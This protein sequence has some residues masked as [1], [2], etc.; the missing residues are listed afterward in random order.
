MNNIKRKNKG[1]TI[2]EV[3]IS[4]SIISICMVGIM[5]AFILGSFYKKSSEEYTIASFLAQKTLE[6]LLSPSSPISEAADFS[7]APFPEPYDQ[8]KYT[9][10]V[11]SF[12]SL[13]GCVKITVSVSTP[14]SKLRRIV[15]L[16][17]LKLK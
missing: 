8:Y 15:E 13:D 4:I 10:K 11:T 7:E 5:D 2:L 6:S 12:E 3:V 16:S 17:A 14:A 1:F 9:V